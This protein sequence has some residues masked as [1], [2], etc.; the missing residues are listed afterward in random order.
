MPFC[1]TAPLTPTLFGVFAFHRRSPFIVGICT[2]SIRCLYNISLSI[3]ACIGKVF[4]C[5][6][7]QEHKRL[8]VVQPL[9][10]QSLLWASS[11]NSSSPCTCRLITI[12][13]WIL[14]VLLHNLYAI[15][16]FL[17]SRFSLFLAYVWQQLILS[18]HTYPSQNRVPIFIPFVKTLEIYNL[19]M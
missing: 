7:H 2:P 5:C 13:R 6:L 4:T 1:L 19:N 9:R 15:V 12:P 8:P 14:W 17:F 10:T 11:R 3:I 18:Q 16:Q